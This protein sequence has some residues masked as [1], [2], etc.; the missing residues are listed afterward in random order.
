M[1]RKDLEQIQKTP[2]ENED[3]SGAKSK[4]LW[5]MISRFMT[6]VLKIAG[7]SPSGLQEYVQK[8]SK[9]N[10]ERFLINNS[11]EDGHSML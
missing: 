11:F 10:S 2:K 3:I 1:S 6:E 9:T 5:S 8:S 7:R 4:D